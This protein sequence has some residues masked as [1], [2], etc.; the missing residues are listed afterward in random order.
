MG[1]LILK[2]DGVKHTLNGKLSSGGYVQ[3]DEHWNAEVDV[4]P[5]DIDFYDDFFSKKE[6]KYIIQLVNENVEW[7]VV[8][9]V[10]KM[11]QSEILKAALVFHDFFFN[12][13]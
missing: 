7:G 11:N 3:F 6:Q 1:K 2:V 5:W 12:L 4:G 8:V 13:Q 9:D 10:S